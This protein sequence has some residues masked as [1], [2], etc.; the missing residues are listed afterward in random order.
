VIAAVRHPWLA[1]AN[2]TKE[3]L[4]SEP[5]VLQQA[6]TEE[7]RTRAR[8]ALASPADSIDVRL[9]APDGSF[10]LY[11]LSRNVTEVP[12]PDAGTVFHFDPALAVWDRVRDAWRWET[13]VAP[14][15]YTLVYVAEC[16]NFTLSFD[17]T[18]LFVKPGSYPTSTQLY[19]VATGELRA[20]RP[21]DYPPASA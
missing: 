15:E 7:E 14:P 18:G 16:G 8:A 12:D 13:H 11:L 19:D 6:P 21:G 10:I 20:S 2:G 1:L 3:Q 5:T 17:G 9:V 4:V